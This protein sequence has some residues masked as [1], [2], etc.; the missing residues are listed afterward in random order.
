MEDNFKFEKKRIKKKRQ[1]A[2]KQEYI[3]KVEN[4]EDVD[5]PN[6]PTKNK[7]ESL[8]NETPSLFSL[9]VRSRA[10]VLSVDWWQVVKQTWL[11]TR[12]VCMKISE[13]L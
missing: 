2:E 6:V 5:V 11:T 12:K 10:L 9:P 4:E 7:F 8:Q 3:V 13:E 1:T